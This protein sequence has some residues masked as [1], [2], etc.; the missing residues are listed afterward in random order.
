MDQKT[1]SARYPALLRTIS[2]TLFE[3]RSMG[4]DSEDC[5][6]HFM[7][8]SSANNAAMYMVVVSGELLDIYSIA[9]NG[10]STVFTAVHTNARLEKL[11]EYLEQL[12]R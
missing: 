2:E 9:G 8:G 7:I 12:N 11:R 5:T 10:E 3:V 1:I 6:V 4:Y